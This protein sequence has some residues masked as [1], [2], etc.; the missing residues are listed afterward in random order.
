MIA[1][2][3]CIR[4]H[5]APAFP[6]PVQDQFGHWVFLSTPGSGLNGPGVPA[7]ENACKKLQPNEVVLTPQEREEALAQ[8]LKFS[9]CMRAHGITNFPDPSTRDGG[10]GVGLQGLDPQSSQFQ[11]AQQACH[12]YQPA[13]AKPVAGPAAGGNA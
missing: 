10:V 2:A 9:E 13:G 5:G 12:Q 11:A 8:L 1:Y 4:S 6:D 3:Q 7:A